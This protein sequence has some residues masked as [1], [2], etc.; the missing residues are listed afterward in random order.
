[1]LTK[2]YPH[3]NSKEETSLSPVL[4]AISRGVNTSITEATATDMRMPPPIV[5]VTASISTMAGLTLI[6]NSPRKRGRTT[7]PLL[8]ML[9]RC[10]NEERH[11]YAGLGCVLVSFATSV[12]PVV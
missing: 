12:V 1:M 4:N 11:R 9:Q 8:G 3:R 2:T 7:R 6:L 5:T 10:A